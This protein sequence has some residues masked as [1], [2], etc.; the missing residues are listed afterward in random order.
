MVLQDGGACVA[1]LYL[2]ALLATAVGIAV[3][4]RVDLARS[5][6]LWGAWVLRRVVV[7]VEEEQPSVVGVSGV[8]FDNYRIRKNVRP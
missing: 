7:T 1:A 5:T 6:E 3:G 4:C 8:C 2:F